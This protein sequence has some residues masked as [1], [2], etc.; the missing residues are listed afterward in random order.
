MALV[1]VGVLLDAPDGVAGAELLGPAGDLAGEGGLLGQHPDAGPEGGLELLGLEAEE[2]LRGV[3]VADV[4]AEPDRRRA[5]L[6]EG[7]TAV[8]AGVDG[9]VVGA[10]AVGLVVDSLVDDGGH[11]LVGVGHVGSP[12]VAGALAGGR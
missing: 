3:G 2:D 1:G 7:A 12:V 9:D 10:D 6:E 8:G 11:A 5:L 4:A